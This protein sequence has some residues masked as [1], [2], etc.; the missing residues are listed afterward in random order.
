MN[1]SDYRASAAEQARTADLLRLMPAGGPS[2]LDIGA[3]D[4]HFSRLVAERFERVIALDLSLPQIEHPRI[5]CLQGNA[6]ELPLPDRSQA[7]VFCAEVL[8][9]IPPPQLAPACAELQ[10]VC[11]GQLLLGV[12]YRQDLRVGRTTCLACGGHSPPWG[13]VNAFDEARLRALFPGCSVEALSF[14]GSNRECSN[15]LSSRLMDWA[16]NPYGTYV[17]DEPCIHCNAALAG[18]PPRN[19]AQKLMTKLAFATRRP[20][21]WLM[22]PHANWM[23]MR[24]RV[25]G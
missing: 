10:R 23:H 2:A 8:E 7:L 9:H 25:P 15:A 1:L 17:Q 16:G 6:A 12:P 5:V 22:Q 11:G 20:S 18:P 4:G 24:L 3:R 21:E 14:V 19:L 13:H